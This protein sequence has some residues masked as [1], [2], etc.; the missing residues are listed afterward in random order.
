MRFTFCDCC[1]IA[2]WITS[3][4]VFILRALVLKLSI[5]NMSQPKTYTTKLNLLHTPTA[6]HTSYK[7]RKC[8][9]IYA[10]FMVMLCVSLFFI[11]LKA[12]IPSKMLKLHPSQMTMFIPFNELFFF[13]LPP[14][15]LS[16]IESLHENDWLL[17]HNFDDDDDRKKKTEYS[18]DCVQCMNEFMQLMASIRTGSFRVEAK[19]VL[20]YK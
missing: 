5:W 9:F 10:I 7:W 1:C 2:I 4:C 3:I 12:K 13:L 14:V 8:I 16:S 19:I 18:F 11:S 15:G 6:L 20:K 17:K